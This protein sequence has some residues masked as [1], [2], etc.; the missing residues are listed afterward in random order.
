MF[1]YQCSPF[2]DTQSLCCLHSHLVLL[3]PCLCLRLLIPW[4]GRWAV[5][6]LAN[7]VSIQLTVLRTR[8]NVHRPSSTL[9]A[10]SW[11]SVYPCHQL[12]GGTTFPSFRQKSRGIWPSSRVDDCAGFLVG[13]LLH[14]LSGM[15]LLCAR[16]IPPWCSGQQ[17]AHTG[18]QTGGS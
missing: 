3:P 14:L 15:E 4:N 1:S 10:V 2:Q 13:A 7:A 9:V 5:L 12:F 6:L 18:C 11:S 16:R 8:S 17:T